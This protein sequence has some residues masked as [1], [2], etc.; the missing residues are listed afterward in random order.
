M[1][2]SS[3]LVE[4]SISTGAS[5]WASPALSPQAASSVVKAARPSVP[6]ARRRVMQEQV[7]A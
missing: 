4:R 3:Q 5:D 1:P 2:S 6:S 7:M